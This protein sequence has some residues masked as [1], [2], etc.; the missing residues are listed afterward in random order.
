[1]FPLLPRPA[2]YL[3][4]PSSE[5]QYH[6]VYV[7]GTGEVRQRSPAFTFSGPRPPDDLVTLEEES[8]PGAD[9]ASDMLLVVPRAELLQ[10]GS[11][12]QR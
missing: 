5:Q 2:S 3:P 12:P 11:G 8:G 4:G 7:S 6:F 10:V 1:V 9:G